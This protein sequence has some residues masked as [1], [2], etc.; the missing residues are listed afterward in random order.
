MGWP[1]EFL[2]SSACLWLLFISK[3][4][5]KWVRRLLEG[6]QRL[7]NNQSSKVLSLGSPRLPMHLL[8]RLPSLSLTLYE[9]IGGAKI[10]IYYFLQEE[11]GKNQERTTS[12]TARPLHNNFFLTD[13]PQD[14]LSFWV[15]LK[16][17]S[18]IQWDSLSR[19]CRLGKLWQFR[20]KELGVSYV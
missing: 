20:V 18:S 4:P 10:Y 9:K 15:P 3:G 14:F 7:V 17:F 16:F 2:S 19:E 8:Q 1:R 12:T 13:A 5:L 6:S 11:E